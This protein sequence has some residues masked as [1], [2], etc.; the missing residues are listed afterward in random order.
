M[1]KNFAGIKTLALIF[2]L[3]CTNSAFAQTYYVMNVKGK[4]TLVSG[5]ILARGS[6]ID[7]ST[8][9]KFGDATAKAIVLNSQNGRMILDGNKSKKSGDGELM[10]FVKE[11]LLPLKSNLRLSTRGNK[12]SKEIVNFKDYFGDAEY[13]IIGDDLEINA[14]QSKFPLGN[15]KMMI[16]L[17]SID[18]KTIKKKIKTDGNKLIFDKTKLFT[19][20][21]QTYD[22]SNIQSFKLYYFNKQTG[23]SSEEANFKPVF[24]SE[25]EFAEEIKTVINFLSGIQGLKGDQLHQEL[26]H[27]VLDVYGKIS[28]P[29]FIEWSKK[30]AELK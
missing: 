23:A 20:K 24:V 14:D 2:L 15:N 29:I 6:K 10:A 26:Y 17:Y 5:Q 28:Y 8:Q 25:Q 22:P 3:I 12:D 13:L 30:N 16:A 19:H 27:Y 4:I 18:N 9:L 1:K 7:A 11:A 21:E